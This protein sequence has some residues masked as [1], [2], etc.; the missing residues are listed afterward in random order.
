MGL[1]KSEAKKA[2]EDATAEED[3]KCL[4]EEAAEEG[5]KSAAEVT[6]DGSF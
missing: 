1:Y 6:D 4:V 2:V 3:S 5:E